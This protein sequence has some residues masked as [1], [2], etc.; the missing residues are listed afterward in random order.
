M[1][2]AMRRHQQKAI[3][4]VNIRVDMD[5]LKTAKSDQIVV[6][7]QLGQT[8][9]GR[10]AC[11][12]GASKYING[13]DALDHLHALRADADAIIVGVGTVVADD[14][15]LTVRRCLFG[16]HTEKPLFIR[17]ED[18][19]QHEDEIGVAMLPPGEGE[20][21]PMLDPVSVVN[22]LAARGYRRI[23][24]EGGASTLSHFINHRAI[25]KLHIL[26]AP[27][28][29]GSGVSGLNL[30]P[31]DS[32]N[33]AIRPEVRLIRFDDGDVLYECTM[34]SVWSTD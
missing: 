9:D 34:Q 7:G 1:A 19:V 28:I 14:P 32:L 13:S 11:A 31:I 24:V 30:T 4:N 16:A 25:D 15:Q 22:A 18:D 17:R 21:R 27:I 10:I 12:N 6:V 8:L 29:L 20:D 2:N 5:S 23:L 33:G 26:M 3:L